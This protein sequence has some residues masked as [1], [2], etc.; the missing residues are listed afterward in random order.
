MTG[1]RRFSQAIS[2]G[3]GISVVAEV[4][5]LD[6]ARRAEAEGA[7][8]VL[9][10][11]GLERELRGIRAAISVPILFFWDGERADR[12]EGVDAC[13]VDGGDWSGG[14]GFGAALEHARLEVGDAFE[15]VPRVKSEEQL[16]EALEKFDPELFVLT[17]PDEGALERVLDLLPDVPAGKLA[18]AD[19]PRT[20]PEDIAELERAGVDGVIVRDGNVAELVGGA[21]PE[22]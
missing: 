10:R 5:S 4:D 11:S 22:V 12:L 14:I 6:A 16:E 2:E 19:L 1:G 7:E 8:A 20:A 21:P 13:L 9:V 18:I 3:D 15:F 17:A